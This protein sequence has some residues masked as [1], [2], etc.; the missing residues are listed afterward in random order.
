MGRA[1]RSYERG[2]THDIKSVFKEK[3]GGAWWPIQ[4]R[5]AE[6]NRGARD[7]RALI[8]TVTVKRTRPHVIVAK[9]A[10]SLVFFWEREN[11]MFS[12][13]RVNHPG[14]TPPVKLILSGV[15]KAGRRL[16]FTRAAPA[17]RNT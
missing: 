12:G 17:V 5:I 4:S 10:P 9:N 15:E 3:A 7:R 6:K 14:S 1:L 11:R 13:P 2:V 8:L 16:T